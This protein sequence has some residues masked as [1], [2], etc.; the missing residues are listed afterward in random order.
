M[1]AGTADK[2]A[3]SHK[4]LMLLGMLLRQ[5]MYG[6]QLKELID[7]HLDFYSDLK[8]PNLY[9]L[10]DRMA[11]DG[12]LA[13]SSQSLEG[14]GG[15]RLVYAVTE[16]GRA[17]F[18]Q[19]LRAVLSGSEPIHNAV[20]VAIFFLNYLPVREA[21]ALLQARQQSLQQQLAATEEQMTAIQQPTA[22]HA[23]VNDHILTMYQAE[24]GWLART[25]AQLGS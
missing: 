12:Y 24:L 20:D 11:A 14:E 22:H 13:S 19:T 2:K 17:L 21:V 9:Y 5:P 1:T 6:Y 25:I 18:H 7:T 10:L 8:K 4:Q 23:I 15:E 3:G 16:A